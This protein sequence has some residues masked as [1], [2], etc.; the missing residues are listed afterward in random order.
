MVFSKEKVSKTAAT[1]SAF[2][3]ALTF[4]MFTWVAVNAPVETTKVAGKE[5]VKAGGFRWRWLGIVYAVMG[6][7]GITLAGI[8]WVKSKKLDL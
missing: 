8:E 5:V 4:V 3:V 2:L 1:M 6:S 7:F